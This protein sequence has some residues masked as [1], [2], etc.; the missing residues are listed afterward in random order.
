MDLTL[1]EKFFNIFRG[2]FN[3]NLHFPRANISLTIYGK[4]AAKKP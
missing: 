1:G 2:N 3:K 4:I